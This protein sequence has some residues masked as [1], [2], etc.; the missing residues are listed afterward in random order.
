MKVRAIIFP[1][2][3]NRRVGAALSIAGTVIAAAIF[4]IKRGEPFINPEGEHRH[5]KDERRHYLRRLI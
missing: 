2:V 4:L 1:A 5:N 3:S